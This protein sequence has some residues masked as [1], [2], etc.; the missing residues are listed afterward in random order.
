VLGSD[1]IFYDLNKMLSEK[2]APWGAHHSRTIID[3]LPQKLA[4]K[5]GVTNPE[6]VYKLK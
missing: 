1:Q 2:G 4:Q 6:K 5:I 3:Q